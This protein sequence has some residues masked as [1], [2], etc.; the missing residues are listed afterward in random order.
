M[1]AVGRLRP[2]DDAKNSDR[3]QYLLHFTRPYIL[4]PFQYC[5][6]IIHRLNSFQRSLYSLKLAR[7]F[8][9]RNVDW[10]THGIKNV[11]PK[12]RQDQLGSLIIYSTRYD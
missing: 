2:L 10:Q 5:A 9:N 11:E 12:L 1:T 8:G 6:V 4:K 3:K 7:I